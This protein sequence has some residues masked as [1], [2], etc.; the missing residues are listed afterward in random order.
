[1]DFI[2]SREIVNKP[3]PTPNPDGP[4]A[5]GAN[6]GSGIGAGS[7]LHP[8]DT[9]A[10]EE[11]RDTSCFDDLN[12]IM[13]APGDEPDQ[14]LQA[15]SSSDTI[16]QISPAKDPLPSFL[17][18]R[19]AEP[20]TSEVF[21]VFCPRAADADQPIAASRT[22][23]ASSLSEVSPE[24][25]AK[26]ERSLVET[27]ESTVKGT[28][29]SPAVEWAG[30]EDQ[31]AE[32]RVPW[33]LIF[34]MSY[35]SAVTLALTWVMW[36]G[37][38]FRPADAPSAS[39]SPADAETLP[40]F[41]SSSPVGV[42]PALPADNL[43]NLGATRQIGDLEITPLGIVSR[44]VA[45]VRS[46]EPKNRRR[47]ESTSLV[48][49]LRVKNVSKDN[50]FAPLERRFL[51]EQSAAL[52]R[53]TIETTPGNCIG[54]FPL[55]LDSEWSIE[56]QSFSILKPG[57]TVETVI[58]SEPEVVDKLTDEM[59]WRI[60]LRIGTYRTDVLGVRFNRHEIKEPNRR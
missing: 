13:A 32:S 56:G 58:A 35:S 4:H 20:R 2:M 41:D 36:T 33:A 54:L 6:R 47:E 22:A 26:F 11:P 40:K 19:G 52:D 31:F 50:E 5:G 24:T 8:G 7:P 39:V 44:R 42:L 37:R 3:H 25:E 17:E 18:E 16:L 60:H 23:L 57:E 34:L 45:L 10:T 53:S 59:I 46:I 21:P 27:R 51:R 12:V 28:N 15:K 30:D 9:P 29:G 49:R 1:M 38:S 55:A 43:A 14:A 48:L